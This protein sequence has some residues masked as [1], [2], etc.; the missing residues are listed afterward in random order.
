MPIVEEFLFHVNFKKIIT[1]R[2]NTQNLKEQMYCSLA[3]LAL[4]LLLTNR[5]MTCD[6][7]ISWINENFAFPQPYC[8]VRRVFKA[9]YDRTD[10]ERGEAMTLVFTNKYGCRLLA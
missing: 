8:G 10:D 5:T 3:D 6:E 4:Q 1:M 7:V 2:E 9:A